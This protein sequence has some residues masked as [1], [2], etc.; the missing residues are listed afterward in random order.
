VLLLGWLLVVATIGGILLT[1]GAVTVARRQAATGAD[2][3]ALAAAMDRTGDPAVA[4]QVARRF[5]QRNGTEAVTCHA[6]DGAV[7]VA[8]MV[9]LPPALRRFGRLSASA[10]AGPWIG[11]STQP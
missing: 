6:G 4:C 10:R 3:A 1:I 9:T 7:Q 2:L 11:G 5:A 8:V